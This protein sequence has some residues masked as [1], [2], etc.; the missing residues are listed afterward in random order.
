M[1]KRANSSHVSTNRFYLQLILTEIYHDGFHRTFHDSQFLSDIH[2]TDSI[3]AI[4]C[5]AMPPSPTSAAKTEENSYLP[6]VLLNKQ[7]LG[8]HGKR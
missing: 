1:H 7:G 2:E 3:Y 8:N 6:M 5:P 4:E